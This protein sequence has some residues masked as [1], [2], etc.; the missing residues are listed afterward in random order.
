MKSIFHGKRRI[1]VNYLTGYISIALLSCVLVGALLTWYSANNLQGQLQQ[2]INEKARNVLDDLDNQIQH[3]SA[4]ADTIAVEDRYKPSIFRHNNYQEMEMLESFTQYRYVSSISDSYFLL[5]RDKDRVYRSDGRT[6]R[7]VTLYRQ[8]SPGADSS[9]MWETLCQTECFN[10]YSPSENA[11]SV[12]FAFPVKMN[13]SP[14]RSSTATLVFVVKKTLVS[15]RIEAVMGA[16]AENAG[17]WYCDT[18]ILAQNASAAV[19][20]LF[21]SSR[22]FSL[23]LYPNANNSLRSA[24]VLSKTLLIILA[25][26]IAGMVSL[27]AWAAYRSYLPI[28]VLADKYHIAGEDELKNIDGLLNTFIQQREVEDAQ[29][30]ERASLM[31]EQVLRLLLYG[32]RSASLEKA[33]RLLQLRLEAA[34][35]CIFSFQSP[36]EKSGELIALL[37]QMTDEDMSTY[38]FVESEKG[39]AARIAVLFAFENER[40]INA[41]E[42]TVR[43]ILQE[44]LSVFKL[45]VGHVCQSIEELPASFAS[46]QT[47]VATDDN[48]GY[49][50]ISNLLYNHAVVT[51]AVT[52]LRQGDFDGA[53]TVVVAFFQVLEQEH[54]SE[55]MRRNIYGDIIAQ[56]VRSGLELQC[57]LNEGQIK[58]LQH[59]Q[60][61][62]FLS[63]LRKVL[64]QWNAQLEKK[65]SV[66]NAET[67]ECVVQYVRDHCTEYEICLEEIGAHFG[68]TGIQVSKLIR[69][70]LD[71]TYKEFLTELRVECAKKILTDE[72][73][74]LAEVCERVGYTNISHFIKV[75]RMSTGQTPNEYRKYILQEDMKHEQ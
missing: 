2:E 7:F 75:F 14:L 22:G 28:Q 56:F 30:E 24:V 19:D 31:T 16:L 35:F 12:L 8:I 64:E 47:E 6:S 61:E 73:A 3:M 13:Y 38:P 42:D 69:R 10:V 9:E 58:M 29:Q 26:C 63:Y 36:R 34:C 23:A 52:N 32:Y 18:P 21:A 5:Y 66:Q 68:L 57:P 55:V 54:I 41:I 50:D 62:H 45:N 1:L 33:A 51:E 74:P 72:T 67:E 37:A 53:W 46:L 43:A 17:L 59:L 60:G 49:R 71:K 44:K 70:R 15:K 4:I 40:M 65:R 48:E 11:D 25:C 27:A 20:H 39:D